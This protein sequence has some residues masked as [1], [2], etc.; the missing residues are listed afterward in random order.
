MEQI[1]ELQGRILAA[2]ERIGA[3]AAALQETARTATEARVQAEAEAQSQSNA[4]HETLSRELDEERLANAQLEERLKVLRNQL[5]E[6]EAKTAAPATDDVG[7]I[8]ALQAEVELLRN[9]VGNTAERDALQAEVARLKQ[10]LEVHGNEAASAREA[11]QDQLDEALATN[12]RLSEQLQEEPDDL[13]AAVDAAALNAEVEALR[14]QLEEANAAVSAAQAAE[15]AARE[16]AAAGPSADEFANQNDMLVQL[17]HAQQELRATADQLRA[18]NAALRDANAEGVGNPDLINAALQSE[19]DTLRASF[20]A[21][22]AHVTAIL[23]KLEPLLA[24]AGQEGSDQQDSPAEEPSVEIPMMDGAPV[25]TLADTMASAR[26]AQPMP[27]G[28][29]I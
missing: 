22:Q 19:V 23:A 6:A 1:E 4:A 8:A 11:L 17:D 16:A 21:E 7:E 5:Q 3:G 2:M 10:E 24:Q 20:A 28:E 29:D 9:E 25:D 15:Q 12:A 18:S 27:E 13:G 14:H 26:T